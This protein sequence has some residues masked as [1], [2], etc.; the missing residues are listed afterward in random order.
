MESTPKG[1]N[2]IAQADKYLKYTQRG[3]KVTFP[4]LKTKIWLA[5]DRRLICIHKGVY[6]KQTRQLR[7]IEFRLT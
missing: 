1:L 7:F 4:K 5:L 2:F 3:R 6:D